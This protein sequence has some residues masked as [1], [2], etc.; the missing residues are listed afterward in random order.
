MSGVGSPSSEHKHLPTTDSESR[1]SSRR[2]GI[3]GWQAG[4]SSRSQAMAEGRLR[5]GSPGPRSVEATRQVQAVL[6]AAGTASPL[7]HLSG[8]TRFIRANN[9]WRSREQP[10]LQP[11]SRTGDATMEERR[12][13]VR[14]PFEPNYNALHLSELFNTS[15]ELSERSLGSLTALVQL[16]QVWQLAD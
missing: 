12:A 10:Q 6:S 1:R 5:Q 16:L 13:R 8:A 11:G 9:E 3:G 15:G 14:N 2:S 4:R 7:L